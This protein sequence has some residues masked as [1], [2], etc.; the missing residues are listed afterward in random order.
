[1]ETVQMY[2]I[3]NE[4][5]AQAMGSNAIAVVDTGSFVSLGNLV[6]SSTQN[7]E[8]FTNTL[9]QRVGQTVLVNRAY[10]SQYRPLIKGD[11]THGALIQ[12]IWVEMPIV[13]EELGTDLVDGQSVDMYKIRKPKPHQSIFGARSP[14][15]I[16]I[17][18][19]EQWLREAFV[20]ESAMNSFIAMVFTAV[21]NKLELCVESIA[22]S[23]VNNYAGI[24]PASQTINLVTLYN[25]ESGNTLATGMGAMF[26][27][28][29]LAW[30]A[31]TIRELARDLTVMST[32]FNIEGAERHTPIERQNLML[33]SK[34]RTQLET[35]ALSSA[36]NDDYLKVARGISV[37]FWQAA[38]ESVLD[39]ATKASIMGKVRKL[40]GSTEEVELKNVIGMIF[41]DDALGGYRQMKRVATTPLNAAALYTNTFWHEQQLWFNATDENF[42]LLTL[43]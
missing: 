16:S 23:A 34:Y 33:L 37:P 19:Q 11:L 26:D 14:W 2:E 31:G 27:K 1:M 28:D 5:A 8:N 18:M 4:V 12:K 42:L 13:E 30:T 17:T 40:D 35:V 41:D 20:S 32:Q 25:Q 38:G 3:L 29:F 24:C 7:V 15:V 10:R 22:K 21:Q 36:F 39:Y 6:L 9:I 43:N